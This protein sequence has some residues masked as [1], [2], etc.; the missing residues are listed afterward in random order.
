L[1]IAIDREEVMTYEHTD[2]SLPCAEAVKAVDAAFD[3]VFNHC[4]TLIDLVEACAVYKDRLRSLLPAEAHSSVESF[5]QRLTR[6]SAAI[7]ES[8][9]ELKRAVQQAV[10]TPAEVLLERTQREVLSEIRPECLE[11]A[12]ELLPDLRKVALWMEAE[13]HTKE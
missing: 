8:M 1:P 11:D 6:S 7:G 9:I 2:P 13:R 10:A 3:A 5:V 4:F 12:F